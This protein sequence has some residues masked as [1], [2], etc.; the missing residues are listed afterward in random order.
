MEPFNLHPAPL[1]GATHIE[2]RAGT[3][4]DERRPFQGGRMK[5]KWFH[6]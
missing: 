3:G 6:F 1:D 5:V 4:F 2:A